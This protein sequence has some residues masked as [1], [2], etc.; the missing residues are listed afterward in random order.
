MM[1]IVRFSKLEFKK[2][3]FYKMKKL[4]ALMI[5]MVFML[6]LA[7]CSS[8]KVQ[9]STANETNNPSNYTQSETDYFIPDYNTTNDLHCEEFL[10]ILKRDGYIRN[11][12]K[13]YNYNTDHIARI[14]NITPQSISDETS[15]IAVFCVNGSHC[16]L[17]VKNT[18]YRYDTFGGAHHQLCLWD[19]DSNGIKDLVS[20]NT[21][22]SGLSFMCVDIFDLTSF[23]EMNVISRMILEQPEFSFECKKGVIYIDGEELTYSN[24]SFN[25]NAF[26][27][28][29]Q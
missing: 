15:D 2:G 21:W 7:G 9:I 6:A 14:V 3:G 5:S 26:I 24:G 18:I 29:A 11:G 12:E 27:E 8:E 19:Y 13:D 23:E 20:Y 25:C 28:E 10:E 1:L 16:F 17:M 4:A 22:G